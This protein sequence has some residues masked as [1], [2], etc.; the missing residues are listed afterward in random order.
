MRRLCYSCSKMSP[1]SLLKLIKPLTYAQIARALQCRQLTSVIMT[2][3]DF[4][5]W[6]VSNPLLIKQSES[7]IWTT[8]QY[9]DSQ[10]CFV[11]LIKTSHQLD[12]LF[13]CLYL[14]LLSFW[15]PIRFV[16]IKVFAWDRQLDY[17]RIMAQQSAFMTTQLFQVLDADPEM[18]IIQD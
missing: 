9:A 3:N 1:N 5:F 6:R 7:N 15:K 2:M 11:Q 10:K 18:G 16:K 8:S 4:W 13:Q 14:Q 12:K 17:Y